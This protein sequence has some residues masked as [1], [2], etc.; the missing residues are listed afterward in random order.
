LTG[1]PRLTAA[2]ITQ[3]LDEVFPGAMEHFTIEAVGPMCSTVR[4]PF[5]PWRL[6]PGGT[7]SG[8]SLMTLRDPVVVPG[9]TRPQP[10][11]A[12]RCARPPS[13]ASS[14]QTRSGDALRRQITSKRA[15]TGC[16]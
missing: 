13:V 10:P 1:Q 2:D 6:R 14:H 8:P 3:F 9:L 4:M 5:Q 11:R 7:I 15:T 12:R 16:R